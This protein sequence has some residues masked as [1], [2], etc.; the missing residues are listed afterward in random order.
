[1][2]G[3][4][5]IFEEAMQ[6]AANAAWDHNWEKSVA[7]YKRA[8]AEFPRDADTL[9]GLG[10]A[11]YGAGQL[12]LALAAYQQASQVTPDDPVLLE[13]I[14]QTQE[15]LGQGKEAAAA[16]VASAERY[17]SQQ[18]AADL[19]FERWK[20]A[21][22]VCPECVQAHVKL[23]QHYQ[24]RGQIKEA[25]TECLALV[26]IYQDQGQ[27]DYATKLCQHALKLSPRN[28][29][30]LQTLDNLRFGEQPAEAE[31]PEGAPGPLEAF[32]EPVGLDF[33]APEAEAA[34]NRGSPAA[35]A[36][37]KALTDLAESF[38]EDED[39]VEIA[40]APVGV[41]TR[42][43]SKAEI[44]GILGRAIDLQTRGEIDQAIDAYER[45]IAAGAEQPAVHF[46][47]GLLYQEKLHFDAAI[48]QFECSITQSDYMLGSH[49]ALGECH[50]AKGRIDEAL[51]HFIEVLKIVDL[52][53]VERDQVDD[54]IQLYEHLTDGY[55][56]K[57]DRNQALEFTNSLVTFLS[58]QGWED[59]I[60]QAR[61][62]LDTL[63]EEGPTLS[64]AEM[65]ETSGAEGILESVALAQEYT[66][67]G[68]F[69]AALEECYSTLWQAPTYLPTHRQLGQVLLAMGKVD[70]AVAK[71]VSIAHAYLARG[72][73]GRAV[74]MYNRA[75]KLAPMDTAVRARLIDVLVSHGKIEGALEH[76]LILAE[77]YYNLAQMDRAREIYQ[78]ALRL[79]PR[80]DPGRR[81]T[82]RILHKIGDID[83]QRVDWKRAVSV[84]E[85]IRKMAPDDER[86]RLTLMGLYHRLDRPELA[87]AELDDL[88]KTYRER[89]KKERIFTILEDA[90][91]ERPD[92]IP[93]RTRLAQ[94]HLDAGNVDQALQHLDKL[95][96][97]QMNAGR[98]SDAQATIRAIIAL[99]P[100]NVEAYRQLLA[101]V[102]GQAE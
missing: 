17:L 52:A 23:L 54:L 38:F 83:M 21:A 97:L 70:E 37:Q 47:L 28:T 60:V 65:L 64:L 77:S 49:F 62:R 67:R 43:L 66:K 13:R 56:A 20:D 58:E 26:H 40:A 79:A 45:V 24:E 44:D 72:N 6:A 57:G 78:E 92:D 5:K 15:Q 25:V 31:L 93:L 73:V 1:V 91:S 16:Y 55:V 84:Y 88:L 96:D 32:S 3:N 29:G 63:A 48:S 19:A 11:Y 94:A 46:N 53:T 80:G 36:R 14:G 71:F 27:I 42:Q 18:Q 59:K 61:Q 86:A 8:L 51:E 41:Q 76:Y 99:N 34:E 74:G 10:Q 95:G 102:G 81:W 89:G 12:E 9:T 39:S 100:P 85:Q 22:R 101:R 82:V 90:V 87:I 35:I 30:L 68:M 33:A 4:R 98:T 50:R 7:E 75:L 2:A 69:Y